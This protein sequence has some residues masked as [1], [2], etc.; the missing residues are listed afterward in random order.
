MAATEGRTRGTSML[1]L[2]PAPTLKDLRNRIDE[3]IEIA[4]EDATW[5]GFDDEAIYIYHPT[6]ST[7]FLAI[8]PREKKP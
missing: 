5:N 4:S 6:D 7:K 1:T 3:A 2:A 8:V